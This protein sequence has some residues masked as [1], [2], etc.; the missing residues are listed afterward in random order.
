MDFFINIL[1][2][3]KFGRDSGKDLEVFLI[4]FVDFLIFNIKDCF[5]SYLK[6]IEVFVI[7]DFYVF[8]FSNEESFKEYGEVEILRL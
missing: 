4:N 8:F 3:L 7:F 6:V 1:S 2:D 5:G